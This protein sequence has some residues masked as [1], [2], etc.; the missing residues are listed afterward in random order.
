MSDMSRQ[1]N[2]GDVPSD[3]TTKTVAESTQSGAPPAG[4][5][6][7]KAQLQFL[8]DVTANHGTSK[9]A[10]ERCSSEENYSPPTVGVNRAR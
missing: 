1:I 8:A 9:R 3:D 4:A 2:V 10:T 7:S 5:M 6:S